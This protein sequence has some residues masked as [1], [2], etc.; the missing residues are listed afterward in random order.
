MTGRRHR[1][2]MEL[3]AQGAANCASAL[4][5]GLP[6]T[7]AIARTATN[8]RAGA[9]TPLAG[10]FHALFLLAFLLVGIRL[11]AWIPLAA[12]AGVLA[13]VAFNM[14]E[15]ERF[16]RLL[17][18]PGPDRAVLLTTFLL[19]VLVD[20]TFAI[21]VGVIMAALFFMGRMAAVVEV[22]SGTKLFDDP[23]DELK[24]DP[25]KDQRQQLPPGVEVF[26]INGPL[27]FGVT[28]RLDD[29]LDQFYKNPRVFILRLRLV[30][31][32]DAS[33]VQA[34]QSLAERCARRN[35]RL[36]LSGLQPGPRAVLDSLGFSPVPGQVYRVADFPA[37]LEL[38]RQLIRDDEDKAGT[39]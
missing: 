37:A 16:R 18:A 19:T 30:P 10:I 3:V 17:A 1:S 14:S 7:G 20:L 8:I 24:P 11:L 34:L 2:N 36:I 15:H 33:G 39:A 13:I 29:V 12:L 5:G 35:I 28:N 21:E 9:R 23:E 32:I 22:N 26:Q 27:F 6:A 31:I 25:A 4:F 38:A